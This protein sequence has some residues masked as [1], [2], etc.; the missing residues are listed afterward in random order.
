MAKNTWQSIAS[1]S[2]KSLYD[3]N[4]KTWKSLYYTPIGA[5]ASIITTGTA[6]ASRIRRTPGASSATIN[7]ILTPSPERRRFCR[8]IASLATANTAQASLKIFPRTTAD[9]HLSLT[10]L[11]GSRKIATSSSMISFIAGAQTRAVGP[12]DENARNDVLWNALQKGN[13]VSW[14]EPTKKA[15]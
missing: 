12:W 7:I 2:W 5:T 15:T 14:V 9:I 1:D 4:Y 3:A 10:A 13:E 8:S 6:T 11:G